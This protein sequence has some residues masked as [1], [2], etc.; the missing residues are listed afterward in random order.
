MSS[1]LLA[2][3][4][5]L[6]GA[7]SNELPAGEILVHVPKRFDF[8]NLFVFD[9]ANNHQGDVEHARQIIRGVG[10][11]ANSAQIR[12][13]LK[14]QFRHL[15]TFI[16]PNH[17]EGSANK[18]IPRFL[19]T[20]LSAEQ[21]AE[22]TEEVRRCGM[23]TMSTPFDEASVELIIKLRIEVIKVASCSATDWPLLERIAKANKP[24][25][26]STGGLTLPQIDGVVSFLEH[27]QVDFAIMHCVAIYPTPDEMLQL[28]QVEVLK[29]RYPGVVI[30]FSTHQ[31]PENTL[32]GPEVGAQRGGD[33]R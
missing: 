32:A 12:G 3:A 2:R 13:A 8:R 15:D 17:R 21:F 20:R 6:T 10:E 26:V 4:N 22:L 14:F 9:L 25:I 31:R 24:V 11:V 7:Y 5:T 33:P 19:S 27:K 29:R 28:N 23:V 1:S 18:H 30:G 16:H